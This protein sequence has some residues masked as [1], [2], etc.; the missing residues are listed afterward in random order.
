[1]R[2]LR[3]QVDLCEHLEGRTAGLPALQQKQS[4]GEHHTA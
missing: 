3:T 4:P 2:R 1:M